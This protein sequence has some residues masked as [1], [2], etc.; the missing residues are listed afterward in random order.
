MAPSVRLQG[1]GVSLSR[2]GSSFF[3][4]FFNL[5]QICLDGGC[6]RRR[7]KLQ[8][9]VSPSLSDRWTRWLVWMSNSSPDTVKPGSC[10]QT[11]QSLWLTDFAHV[12]WYYFKYSTFPLSWFKKKTKKTKAHR[13]HSHNSNHDEIYAEVTSNKEVQPPNI[14]ECEILCNITPQNNPLE[15]IFLL[16]LAVPAQWW[17]VLGNTVLRQSYRRTVG[18]KQK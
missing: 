15:N 18:R 1:S 14:R 11:N 9:T 8:V 5:D 4:F 7:F 12:S 13:F 17:P 6:R 16:C 2:D 3:F 10:L